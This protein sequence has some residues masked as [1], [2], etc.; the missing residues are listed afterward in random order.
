MLDIQ[1]FITKQFYPSNDV[2]PKPEYKDKKPKVKIDTN[3][4]LPISYLED[5]ELFTLSETVANDLE[6]STSAPDSKSIYEYLFQPQ[7][8]FAKE[9][10]EKW[11][12]KYTTNQSYLKD[13]QYVVMKM[14]NYKTS[15]ATSNYNVDCNK[16]T[17]I[18][19]G[20][21]L[22]KNF[23]D[24]YGYLEWESLSQFNESSFFLQ[25]L[26]VM[27]VLS[28]ALSLLIPV[29]FLIFPFLIL[30]FQGIPITFEVYTMVLKDIAKNHFIGKTLMTLDSLSFEKIVYL[31]VTLGLYLMQIYQNVNQ[32]QTFYKNI[33]KINSHLVELRN[34]AKYSI[35]SMESHIDTI[36]NIPSYEKIT[37]D[38]RLHI[39]YLKQI[40][41]ELQYIRDFEFTLNT[42]TEAGYML[43][44]YYRLHS[45]KNHE[46]GLRYAIGFEGYI[47]NLLGVYDN[48]IKGKI[49]FA[50]FDSSENCDFKEQYYPPLINE[51]PVKN[52]CDFK[53]NMIISSP[54]KSGKTTILKTT[55][56]NII[57]TQQMG[58][59]FYKEAKINP[60]THIHS[61]LNIPDTSGRDSLFQAESRR[62]KE[63]IDV[64]EKYKDP[65]KC[66]HFCI[67]DELYSGTNPEEASKAGY[68]FLKYLNKFENVNFILTTHYF[69]ICKKFNKS[70]RVQNY[71]MEVNVLEDGTFEYT[72]KIKEGISD[73]KGGIRVLKDMDYPAE[74]INTIEKK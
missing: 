52:N 5:S 34:F 38:I 23:L 55:T 71:K 32:C 61:Y 11:K 30:K 25:T 66:R 64:I 60:Y 54:N 56:I 17:S 63:I 53:K 7:H 6:L 50:E 57:F 1:N 19:E 22:D 18:W 48:M 21:K 4:K 65:K 70:E 40:Y 10:I 42:F 44:C 37:S 69:S 13:T 24:K 43:K 20:L 31:I 45:N 16:L 26:T 12:E 74:I 2:P 27:N 35:E 46:D 8:S 49:A 41:A 14:A 47:N 51:T 67:F 3:F 59:G 72:Y 15:M 68:A 29:F 28:P 9:M 58:C 62:C 33:I 39:N 36:R 73:I